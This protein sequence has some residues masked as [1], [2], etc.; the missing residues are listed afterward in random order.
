MRRLLRSAA[1]LILLL[2]GSIGNAQA[3]VITFEDLAL[4]DGSGGDVTSGGFFFDTLFNHS[5]IDINGW[6]TSNGTKFMMTDNVGSPVGQN[7]STTFSP[8]VGA[9]FTLTSIDISEAGGL[10]GQTST[11]AR[12]VVV[13][14]NV[15]GGGTVTTTLN[16]DLNFVDGTTANYFQTFTFGPSW[17]NLSSVSLSGIGSL[18]CGNRQ[19][20]RQLLRDRQHRRHCCLSA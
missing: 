11:S 8:T 4:N 12:Q 17:T 5:H 19:P 14:G 13:T 20:W 15:A 1:A 6:G 7:T 10:T 9:P 16:L 18:C 3:A 2:A